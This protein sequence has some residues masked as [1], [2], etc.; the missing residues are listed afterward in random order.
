MQNPNIDKF[1]SDNIDVLKEFYENFQGREDLIKWVNNFPKSTPKIA[2]EGNSDSEIAVIIPTPSVDHP[3]AINC[4]NSIFNGLKIIF[5]V[6]SSKVFNL[7]RSYNQGAKILS[8]NKNIK[9]VIFSNVDM[10]R[11]ESPKKLIMELQNVADNIKF[12]YAKEGDSHSSSWRIGEYTYLR[13]LVFSFLGKNRR[14]KANLENKFS[15]HINVEDNRHKLTRNF[16]SNIKNILNFGDF[17]IFSIDLLKKY[18]YAPFDELFLNGMEDIDLSL[19]LYSDLNQGEFKAINYSIG[20]MESG[21][22]GRD[23]IRDFR[24]IPSIAYFNEKQEKFI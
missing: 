23:I 6:D 22:R 7:A 20:S 17:F 15:I 12:C 24:N 9:W 8:A 21:I 3:L 10:I 16:V 13:K 18:N 1:M 14:L 4:Q 2:E 11:L 19:R 5:T